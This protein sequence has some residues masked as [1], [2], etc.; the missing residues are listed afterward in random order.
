MN[1]PRLHHVVLLI[2]LWPGVQFALE[3][4]RGRLPFP[5]AADRDD[6][7]APNDPRRRMEKRMVRESFLEM[8]K[9]S[10]KLVEMS[11]QLRDMLR[12][13]TEDELSISAMKKAE[14]IEKLAERVKNRM[15]NL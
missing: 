10:E 5:P 8:Q 2:A 9:E 11:T 1:T 7:R 6:S 15:K 4:Q 13:T 12:E 3:A 14:E